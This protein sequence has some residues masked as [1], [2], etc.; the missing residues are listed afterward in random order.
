MPTNGP[1]DQSAQQSSGTFDDLVPQKTVGQSPV[2]AQSSGTFDDLVPSG[3]QS[4]GTDWLGT[5]KAGIDHAAMSAT[6]GFGKDVVPA[7]GSLAE[8]GDLSRTSAIRQR[9]MQQ[10][11]DEEAQHPIASKVGDVA[12]AVFSP[13][14]KVGAGVG[15]LARGAGLVGRLGQAAVA[16]GTNAALYGAGSSD[17][18]LADRAKAAGASGALGAVAGPAIDVGLGAVAPGIK[19][20]AQKSGLIGGGVSPEDAAASVDNARSSAASVQYPAARALPDVKDDVIYKTIVDEPHFKDAYNAAREIL[21]VRGQDVPPLPEGPEGQLASMLAKNPSLASDPGMVD[22]I[23]KGITSKG[24][25][26]TPSIPVAAL[27]QMKQ[28]LDDVIES[29]RTPRGLA[30]ALRSRLS[31]LLSR[32]DEIAPEYAEARQ[33]FKQHSQ[34]ADAIEP[35]TKGNSGG[36]NVSFWAANAAAH[37]SPIGMMATAAGLAKSGGRSAAVRQAVDQMAPSL[38]RVSPDVLSTVRQAFPNSYRLGNPVPAAGNIP[39]SLLALLMGKG[40]R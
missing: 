4:G 31:G 14:N 5:A 29:N 10:L 34:L 35:G 3:A 2:S 19:R 8:T 7:L 15:A 27:D 26:E 23:R 21:R 6:F 16:G 25:V 17:G 33:T 20:F 36:P 40:Q 28:G 37:G 9:G 38:N 11:A 30:S 22:A 39:P 1:P 18:S 12:G 13:I 32:L 24:A